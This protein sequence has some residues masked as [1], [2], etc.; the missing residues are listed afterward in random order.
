MFS[1]AGV[2]VCAAA[3]AGTLMVPAQSGA[4]GAAGHPGGF[5]PIVRPVHRVP[6]PFVRPVHRVPPPFVNRPRVPFAHREFRERHEFPRRRHRGIF[7]LPLFGYGLPVTYGDDG[8]FYGRY[9]DPSDVPGPI[10]VPPYGVPPALVPPL[11]GPPAERVGCS[12]QT[13]AVPSPSGAERSVTI[14]RC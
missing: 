5:R 13:V 10:V 3:V 7:T 11:A 2:A 9:Y 1:R 4:R 6:P 14:T 8:A 12:S